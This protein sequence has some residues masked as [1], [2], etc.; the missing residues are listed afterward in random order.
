[1]G[2]SLGRDTHN[3]RPEMGRSALGLV[4]L[5]AFPQLAAS[6]NHP[7]EAFLAANK[8][9]EGVTTLPSGLQYKILASGSGT[10]HPLPS[11]TCSCHYEGRTAQ[12][13]SAT[14]QGAV[15]DS[16][17]ARGEPTQFA[18]NQVI[19]GWTEVMQMMVAGDKWELYIPSNLAYGESG[20]GSD[21]R[22]G[23]ALVFKL[24]LLSLNGPGKTLTAEEKTTRARATSHTVKGRN[25]KRR[26]GARSAKQDK[27]DVNELR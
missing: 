4:A 25:A 9:N 15:F 23:D 7:G 26:G 21:I 18:P 13:H 19:S 14:P 16:S 3:W 8:A 2:W 10:E 1:V 27:S 12:A 5:L 24:E 6:T 11:T 22:A 17:Y 20:A